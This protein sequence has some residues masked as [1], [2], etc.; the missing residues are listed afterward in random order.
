MIYIGKP[1]P[2]GDEDLEEGL[3][4]LR[5]AADSDDETICGIV[6][7]LVPTFD[8]RKNR[9]VRAGERQK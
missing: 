9:P 3:A 8:H 6:A 5:D 1:I 2:F 7:G 4:R